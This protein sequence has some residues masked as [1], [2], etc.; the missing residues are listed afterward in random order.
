LKSAIVGV[1]KTDLV[2]SALKSSC[3]LTQILI[4]RSVDDV[5]VTF[6]WRF[7]APKSGLGPRIVGHLQNHL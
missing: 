4:C 2:F 1:G 6:S 3:L 7:V 5:F